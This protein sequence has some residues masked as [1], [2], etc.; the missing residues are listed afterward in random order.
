MLDHR[1]DRLVVDQ[2]AVLDAV[3]TGRDGVLDRIG[4]VRVRG[5]AQPAPVRLVDDRAQFLVR[6]VLRARRSRQ[7]HHA[8]RAADLDQLGAVFDL[9]A[10]RLADLVDS[11]GDAFLDRQLQHVRCERGE[12]RRIQMPAGRGDRVPGRHHPR[13]VDPARVDGLA[14]RDVEQVAAGLDEQPEV[15]HRGEPGA[16]RA[17]GIADRA[18][19]P[20]RRI[21]LDLGQPGLLAAP[22]HQEVDLH[23][24]QA[25][26]QDRSPRS[27]SSPSGVCHR[28]RRSGRRRSAGCRARRSRR[29]RRRAA[30][31]P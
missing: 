17:A 10:H 29:R 27:I 20:R 28:R 25:G 5:D 31:R 13:P 3:D 15:A 4:A 14:Q 6:I 9:V 7:R 18:Q 2:E 16:Q 11:V 19:H 12:H 22:A 1:R 21:V 26:Q 30:R 23:V 24:H 8:A